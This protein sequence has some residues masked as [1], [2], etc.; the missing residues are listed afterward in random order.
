MS[1]DIKENYPRSRQAYDVQF[2]HYQIL[3]STVLGYRL[4]N[5]D[6]SSISIILRHIQGDCKEF[7]KY[8]V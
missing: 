6:I 3:V 5:F 1:V 4:G 7:A 2:V 8:E